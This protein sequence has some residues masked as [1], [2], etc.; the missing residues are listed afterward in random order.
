MIYQERFTGKER[1]QSCEKLEKCG[2]C[3]WPTRSRS[4]RIL[5]FG[6]DPGVDPVAGV[7]DEYVFVFGRKCSIDERLGSVE[8]R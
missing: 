5:V 7:L 6:V 1:V 2:D 4:S 8:S 3:L